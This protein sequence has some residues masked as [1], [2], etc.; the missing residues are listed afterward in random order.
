M[1]QEAYHTNSSPSLV[2]S[3]HDNCN[4]LYSGISQTNLNKLQ[5]IQNSLA[6]VITNTSK[7]QHVKLILKKFHWLNIKQRIYYKLCLLTYKTLTNQQ[8]SYLFN[9]LSFLSHSV[10]TRSSDSLVLS[11]PCVRSSLDKRAFSVI[12]PRHDS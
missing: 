2:S 3:K 1:F 11:I 4:S 7:Y 6:R 8:P 12:G 9:S 10:S 5:H